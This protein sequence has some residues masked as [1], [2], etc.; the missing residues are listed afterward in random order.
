MMLVE[1][2]ALLERFR[3]GEE[4]ALVAVYTHYAPMVYRHLQR[5]FVFS[6]QGRWFRVHGL[7][8]AAEQE[9]FVQETFVRCFAEKARLSYDGERPYWP[10][11][12]RV[13]E[14]LLIEE[15]RRHK[16]VV[17][18][19]EEALASLSE[20]GPS[21]QQS[22]EQQ[23]LIALLETF[24]ATCSSRDRAVFQALYEYGDSQQQ[25]AERLGL[26]RT[27]IRTSLARLRR[28]LLRFLRDRGYLRA[29]TDA[30]RASLGALLLCLGG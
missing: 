9:S 19:S 6:S 8:D 7:H 23:E 2:P 27:Q 22:L 20:D 3:R 30:K 10:Y 16:K 1:T 12:M 18:L 14:R 15:R 26:G 11:V 24:L 25:A 29:M 21:V 17:A 13:C 28:E 5:G 4:S